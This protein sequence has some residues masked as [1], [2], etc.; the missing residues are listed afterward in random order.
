VQVELD[1]PGDLDPPR[2][3]AQLDEARGIR[4]GLGGDEGE[5]TEGTLTR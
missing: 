5:S 1:A 2:L 4:L 3:G